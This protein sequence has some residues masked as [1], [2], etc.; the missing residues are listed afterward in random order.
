MD[1]NEVAKLMLDWGDLKDKMDAIEKQVSDYILAQET[2]KTIVVGRIRAT[3]S[4]GRRTFDYPAACKDVPPE[5]IEKH[6]RIEEVTDW[7]EIAREFDLKVPYTQAD[8][9]V[10]LKIS[11]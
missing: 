1:A 3:Y 10:T 2:P 6:T 8:P 5:V 4:Q 9:K 11:E 7:P